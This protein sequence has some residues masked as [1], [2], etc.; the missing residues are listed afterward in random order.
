MVWAMRSSNK[1]SRM[2]IR[3]GQFLHGEYDIMQRNVP[4]FHDIYEL[5]TIRVE[6]QLMYSV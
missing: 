6:G 1:S 2:K 3:L 5:Y 4:H